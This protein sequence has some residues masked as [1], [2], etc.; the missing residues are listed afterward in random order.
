[1]IV[2]DP[3]GDIHAS[4]LVG[5]LKA[6]HP[7][8]EIFGVG[9]P[10]MTDAGFVSL[11]PIDRM[12]VMGFFEVLKHLRFFAQVNRLLM[13]EIERR[14]P[15]IIVLVDY[16]GFNIRLAQ[17]IRR[18]FPPGS[19]Y[20]PKLL[21]Y[22]SPQVWAWKSGRVKTLTQVLDFMAVVFP[23]E[24]E[25]YR[26]AGL[27]VEFVGHPLLDLPPP[28]SKEVLFEQAGL[29]PDDIPVALLPGSRIQE[30]E[31]H[32]PVFVKAFKALQDKHPGLFAV[33]A[34]S[35]NIPIST[36]E[37]HT[38]GHDRVVVLQ[39]WTRE[40]MAHCQV[41]CVVSGTAT[42]ETAMFGTPSVIVYKANPLTYWIAKRVV[43]VPYIGMVNILAG[44]RIVKELLQKKVTP[45]NVS[46]ELEL[47]LFDEEY[48]Q[49]MIGN[50]GKIRE[51]LGQPG[52]GQRVARKI[53]DLAYGN[54]KTHNGHNG[55]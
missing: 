37:T 44:S 34:A 48:R 26:E 41:A 53:L 7:D 12:A 2:G 46:K 55:T 23:F 3:S 8:S 40:I 22:I 27:P 15:Q 42:V 13:E 29:Q 45:G 21:Y 32:L 11:A 5:A 18:R 39:G 20:Q 4:H 54:R 25:I 30:V 14:K 36:Y 6:E 19:S 16:P 50:L 47:L 1:M 10:R 43:K 49:D 38:A 52:S 28:R 31:R 33:V 24:V 51:Q 9:G 17:R 35:D